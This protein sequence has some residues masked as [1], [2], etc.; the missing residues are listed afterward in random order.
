[1]TGETPEESL[2]TAVRSYASHVLRCSPDRVT[3]VTRFKDGNRH[4]VYK[5][6]YLGPAGAT[7]HV[8]VRVSNRGEPADCARAEWEAAVLR[9]VGG[10]AGP[11]LYDFR[12]TSPWFDTPAMCLQF[13][14]G[15]EL[16]LSSVGLEQITRLGSVMMTVH[17]QPTDDLVD[18][19]APTA[20]I[21]SYAE[22]RLGSILSALAW[23]RDPLP[24]AIQ[25]RLN[26][27]AHSVEARLE[28]WRDSVSFNTDEPLVL[29]HG[30]IAEG[31]ILWNPDPVLIDWEYARP[32]D[33]AD[34][35]AYTFDQ[36]GL[37]ADQRNAFWAGYADPTASQIRTE[38]IVDRVGWW[39]PVT[40]LG[41]TLWWAERWVRSADAQAAGK[42]DPETPKGVEY[43][44]DKVVSRLDRLDVLLDR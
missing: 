29:L 38:Q 2:R 8:V 30:D 41:S 18:L 20:T 37:A 10:A 24:A 3:A 34:E 13:L 15:Q 16:D 39:E 7:D 27:G 11:L 14:R 17:G 12:C 4:G 23:V 43:Y 9:K 5:V 28:G 36:N 6:S 44:V 26:G 21:A 1:M 35:I 22:G 40:L 32:G 19:P 25:A 33:P 42:V 31:N